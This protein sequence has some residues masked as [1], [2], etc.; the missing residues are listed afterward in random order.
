MI[1]HSYHERITNA[2]HAIARVVAMR[3]LR[4]GGNNICRPVASGEKYAAKRVSSLG[5]RAR[6]K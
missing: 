2:N 5:R 3:P 6:T 4:R 1:E